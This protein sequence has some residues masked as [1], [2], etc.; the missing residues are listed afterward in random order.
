MIK[1]CDMEMSGEASVNSLC[2]AG[3]SPTEA[4]RTGERHYITVITLSTPPLPPPPRVE[5]CRS[6]SDTRRG[7]TRTPPPTQRSSSPGA[8]P[9][10]SPTN[11]TPRLPPLQRWRTLAR[12]PGGP[13]SITAS[14]LASTASYA[15]D[16]AYSVAGYPDFY[17][18]RPGF[19]Q[20]E[21]VLTEENVKSGFAGKPFVSEVVRTLCQLGMQSAYMST[22]RDVLD[23]WTYT[24]ASVWR[25]SQY[26]HAAGQGPCREAR[27]IYAAVPVCLHAHVHHGS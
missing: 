15:W 19:D 3:C 17:P 10:S 4:S 24:P 11:H 18:S 22:G 20:P 23:A 9:R 2:V 1:V 14:T 25:M 26:A 7:S 8:S 6:R 12:R 5:L 13:S 21:D 16:R 27:G